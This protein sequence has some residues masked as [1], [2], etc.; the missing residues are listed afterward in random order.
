MEKYILLAP[1]PQSWRWKLYVFF[2][3]IFWHTSTSPTRKSWK[4]FIHG[5][6]EHEHE[7]DEEN[8]VD[9]N[10][11]HFPCKHHGCNFVNPFDEFEGRYDKNHQYIYLDL[12]KLEQANMRIAELK[13]K[14]LI[15]S[16]LK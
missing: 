13:R 7:F 6:I 12:S 16:K 8:P 15:Y 4:E 2:T 5:L 1:K 11:V 9:N 3:F 10:G 14:R